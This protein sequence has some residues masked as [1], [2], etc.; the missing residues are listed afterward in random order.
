MDKTRGTRFFDITSI[1]KAHHPK[2]VLLENV[3]NGSVRVT[4]TSGTIETLRD[5]GYWVSDQPAIFSPQRP[6]STGVST[7]R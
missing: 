2:V 6:P 1:I 3:R 7:R 5:L 4:A